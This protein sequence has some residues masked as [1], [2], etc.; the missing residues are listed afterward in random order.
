MDVWAST[1]SDALTI[2]LLG[3]LALMLVWE[4]IAPYRSLTPERNARWRVNFLLYAATVI[5]F[6]LLAPV[7]LVAVAR[8]SAEHRFGF[9]NRLA[10]PAWLVVAL[11]VLAM[12]LGKYLQHR[13]MHSVSWL[14]RIHRTHHSDN[15]MD[16][17]T[18]LRFHPIETMATSLADAAIIVVLGVPPLAVA[19]YR[20]VRQARSAFVHGNVALQ[21]K[22]DAILRTT[23]A[24]PDFHRVHHSTAA[25]EQA[26]NLSGGLVWW[27]RLLG[28]YVPGSQDDP[29]RM[30]LGLAERSPASACSLRLALLEP[31][32]R[33]ATPPHRDA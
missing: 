11:S 16:A 3:A 17:T 20:V 28:T 12:D 30:P 7:S 32:N 29:R 25:L 5:V 9:F 10:V 19:A 6:T 18:S 27:D 22:L 13:A 15:E 23:F 1:S 33:V 4:V 8:W 24:T 26:R 2:T 14:W 21:P 31:F